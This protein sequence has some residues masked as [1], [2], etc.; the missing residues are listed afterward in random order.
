MAW[1]IQKE[2]MRGLTLVYY[3][4]AAAYAMVIFASDYVFLQDYPL[5]V[6][7]GVV[8]DKLTSGTTVP[9]L[10]KTYPIPNSFLSVGVAALTYPLGFQLAAKIIVVAY[11]I[12]AFVVV[13]RLCIRLDASV[14]VEK[15]LLIMATVVVGSAFWNGWINYQ[16]GLLFMAIYVLTDS[17][18]KPLAGAR[19]ALFG[20]LI[21]FTHLVAFAAFCTYVAYRAYREGALRPL[22]YLVPAGIL[23][24]WYV[25]GRVTSGNEGLEF[26]RPMQP[27]IGYFIA[28]KAYTVLKLGPF[29]NFILLNGSSYLES[30]YLVYLGLI[31]VSAL[32]VGVIL[33]F[34]LRDGIESWRSK[35]FI[36]KAGVGLAV[37]GAFLA[38]PSAM[39]GIVNLGERFLIPAFAASIPLI[40]L[41]RRILI[42]L[43]LVAGGFSLYNLKFMYDTRH[44]AEQ[45]AVLREVPQPVAKGGE[46]SFGTSETLQR[47]YA[48]TKQKYLNHRVFG[49]IKYYEA[50]EKSDFSLPVFGTGVVFNKK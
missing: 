9:Y 32:F 44:L 42:G 14:A 43:A 49:S 23:G 15:S 41:P 27:G 21:F 22:Y 34:L 25:I 50:L 12:G 40:R 47:M 11:I 45:K 24:V 26:D 28:Y 35:G 39:L 48:R 10:L 3:A 5:W 46:L 19:V 38:M 6:Y 30:Q 36:G 29:Q 37:V 4:L 20:I 18:S 13:H 8:I 17:P 33:I 1:S 7:E 16:V 2:P 31:A